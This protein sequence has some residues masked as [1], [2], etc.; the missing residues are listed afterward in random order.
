VNILGRC[1]VV[2][3]VVWGACTAVALAQPADRPMTW[4]IK[5]APIRSSLRGLCVVDART[6]WASGTEGAYLR[7]TDGGKTWNGGSVDGSRD[8]DFRDVHAFDADTALVLS[9]GLPARIHKT[10]DGGE[11]WSMKYENRT[12]GVFFDAMAFWDDRNGIAFSDPVDGK[13]VMISTANAGDTWKPL[14]ADRI[15]P[16]LEGEAG[17]AASGTCLAVASDSHVW[18]GLGG[19]RARV[20]HSADRGQTW[21]VTETPIASGRQSAGIFSLAFRDEK[22]GVAVGGDF[23][24]PDQSRATAAVTNDGGKTWTVADNPPRGFRSC[25]AFVPGTASTWVAVGANGTDVSFD[26]GRSWTASGEA[27]LNAVAF[28][29]DGVGYAVGPEGRMAKTKQAARD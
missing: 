9:A 19:P 21:T 13:L 17:F 24:E 28:A 22:H 14:P 6:F 15:P 29:D 10:T 16:A 8:L 23:L 12:E 1:P 20:F 4:G 18:I 5:E 3:G 27:A 11:T 7:T 25:V 26:D 2:V